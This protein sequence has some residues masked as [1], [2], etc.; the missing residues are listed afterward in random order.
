MRRN[1][2]VPYAAIGK[3]FATKQ[4]GPLM[5]RVK[6]MFDLPS[7]AIYFGD[8]PYPTKFGTIPQA[9]ADGIAL[10]IFGVD[11]E[12]ARRGRGAALAQNRRRSRRVRANS[13]RRHSRRM[14]ANSRR[15]YSRRLH[16]NTL[17]R[18]VGPKAATTKLA[19]DMYQLVETTEGSRMWDASYPITVAGYM[20]TGYLRDFKLGGVALDKADM[21]PG[22]S[23]KGGTKRKNVRDVPAHLR[24]R[25]PR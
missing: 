7:K 19:N 1:P 11:P 16:A 9:E 13:R 5:G 12:R 20:T 24:A 4:R 6:R 21:R 23:I 14:R 10:E 17:I 22:T 18:G 25:P 2:P 8:K 15:R 3:S